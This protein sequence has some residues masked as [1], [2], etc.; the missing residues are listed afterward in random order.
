MDA[1]EVPMVGHEPVV[2]VD[3]CPAGWVA[4]TRSGAW[5]FT[6][7]ARLLEG[8]A[9][10]GIDMPIG[11]PATG[12]RAAEVA[13]RRFLGGRAASR[14]FATP[15]RDLIDATDYATANAH[16][17]RVHRRGISRQA[18]A[19][20]PRI[21]AL[22]AIASPARE[23]RLAEIHPECAFAA[24]AGA[25]LVT[26]H[27]AAGIEQREALLRARFGVLP[28]TPRGAKR[29]DL[30]DAYAVLWSAERFAAGTHVTLGDGARDERGL[31][32]RIVY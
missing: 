4:A 32:M 16:S 1:Q 30:L 31:E 27:S 23:H 8:F 9:V 10:I 22:D 7:L 21:R 28:P 19:L 24:M 18:F 15:P 3:G 12:V 14:V 17:R 5:V 2:G 26:K 11:L 25:T 6:D 13:A 20:V 29:D